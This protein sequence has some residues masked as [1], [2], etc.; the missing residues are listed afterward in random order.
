MGLHGIRLLETE[1]MKRVVDERIIREK[2]TA[3]ALG[4]THEDVLY[5]CTLGEGIHQS[6]R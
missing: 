5:V 6:R 1:D 4:K 2:E 3:E